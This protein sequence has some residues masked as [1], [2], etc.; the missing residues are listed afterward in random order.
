WLHKE[1]KMR[2][3][4]LEKLNVADLTIGINESTMKL[5]ANPDGTGAGFDVTIR[6]EAPRVRATRIGEAQEV[7]GPPFDLGDGDASRMI[8][9]YDKLERAAG[10]RTRGRKAAAEGSPRNP[11]P[12]GPPKPRAAAER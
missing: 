10:G 7:A 2:P 12:P 1:I 11:S 3:T 6:A 4:R 9:L 5:R 8:A